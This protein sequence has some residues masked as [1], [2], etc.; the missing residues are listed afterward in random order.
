MISYNLIDE[1]W[2]PVLRASGREGMIAPADLTDPSDPP[3][4][5]ASVRPDFNGALLQFLIG[6]VQTAAA[7][8][9][10]AE[11][12]RLYLRPPAPEVLAACFAN[13]GGAFFVGGE[14][15]RFLQDQTMPV[16][17]ARRAPISELLIDRYD[18]KGH[19]LPDPQEPRVLGLPA[20]AAAL[21]TLQ[22][23]APVGGAGHMASPRGGGPLT[24]VIQGATLW[25]SVWLNVLCAPDA[26]LLPGDPRK[27]DLG[28]KLP[29]MG[30]RNGEPDE[31]G[32]AILT[33]PE[34][35]HPLAIYWAMPRRI[36]LDF[37]TAEEGICGLTG[38]RGPVI[39]GYFTRPRGIR[40]RDF[41][42]PLTPYRVAKAEELLPVRGPQEG[43][44]YRDWPGFSLGEGKIQPARILTAY[45]EEDRGAVVSQE[46]LRVFGYH[47]LPAQT[48][49]T[50]YYDVETPLLFPGRG[51]D[52]RRFA[53]GV[54]ACAEVADTVRVRLIQALGAA[55]GPSDAALA[56][57]TF[58]GATEAAFSDVVRALREEGQGG[59]SAA[60]TKEAF[61]R[62]LSRCAL[63]AFDVSVTTA[64]VPRLL[65]SRRR[66]AQSVTPQNEKL[67]TP[68][69]LGP[70]EPPAL[71]VPEEATAAPA[72][73]PE[74]DPW[75]RAVRRFAKGLAPD[76]R[77]ELQRAADLQAL[78]T[79]PG[80]YWLRNLLTEEGFPLGP[81]HRER[82]A[83][84]AALAAK[85]RKDVPGRRM[86]AHLA[87][88]GLPEL[89]FRR[90]LSLEGGGALLRPLGDVLQQLR[91][92]APLV[93][94]TRAVLWWGPRT[95]A[96]W[97]E[98]FY[99][100]GG[101]PA[102]AKETTR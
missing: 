15:P 93:D 17:E 89:K 61:L 47:V 39:S 12:R 27:A 56:S 2:I 52:R 54:T 38:A 8:A 69:G 40:Y 59:E 3:I 99:T 97:A 10:V 33:Y 82:V 71:L 96:E 63:S 34:D 62:A 45:E 64:D 50:A 24:T 46:R 20:A 16:S 67:R 18:G 83:V 13:F 22:L 66:L 36:V 1:P 90:L 31:K 21:L 51:G 41:R 35:L 95:R 81:P 37:A 72:P 23:N 86:G 68:L 11:W 78:Y 102:A 9:D 4:A 76:R 28:S 100:N 91:G 30:K 84:V 60:P 58:W 98:D 75:E 74:P 70:Y 25:Q 55:Q 48:V 29:W 65:L 101:S 80:L 85:V 53:D 14:M 73:P 26:L 88:C 42:H 43:I 44:A 77:A 92:Q 32:A 5:L 94:L 19:F 79:A 7:P 49:A 87:A 6:L 57:R